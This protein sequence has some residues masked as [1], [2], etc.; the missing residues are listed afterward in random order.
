MSVTCQ[1][2]F[3]RATVGLS[4]TSAQIQARACHLCFWRLWRLSLVSHF[5]IAVVEMLMIHC[6][7]R[8]G[9]EKVARSWL[10]PC[11]SVDVHLCAVEK[12]GVLSES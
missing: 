8:D 7:E 6:G 12:W 3:I 11:C 9:A 4:C 2:I 10:D 1:S 5:Y